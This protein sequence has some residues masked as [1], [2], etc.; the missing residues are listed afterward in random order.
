MGLPRELRKHLERL[1]ELG[2]PRVLAPAAP[3][4]AAE[5]FAPLVQD[6]ADR[7][8]GPGPRSFVV[9]GETAVGKTT[10]LQELVRELREGPEPMAVVQL[11]TGD[12][13]RGAKYIGE[14]EERLA[15]LIAAS[16]RPIPVVIW[17]TNV[18]DLIGAGM[19]E[20]SR[21]DMSKLLA[22]HLASGDVAVIGESSPSE[23]AAG[24]GQS[25]L[26]RLFPPIEL[27]PASDTE[28]LTIL[29]EVRRAFREH[30]PGLEI[31]VESVERVLELSRLL[32]AVGE[33]PGRGI[34]LFEMALMAAIEED[35]SRI[36]PAFV[37][38]VLAERTGLPKW[39]FDDD[40]AI[41]LEELEAF[42]TE[43]VLGQPEAVATMVDVIALV[44]AGLNDPGKPLAVLFFV[45]PTGVGKT[46]IAKALAERLFGS[47]ERMV[48]ID[49]SEFGDY[50]AAARLIGY[51]GSPGILTERVK[52]QP[53]SVIL[54]D[55]IEKAADIAFDLFLQVFDDGRLSDGS[56]VTV[57]F[58]QTIVVMT[59]NLGS[60]R[61]RR[62]TLG[63]KESEGPVEDPLLEAVQQFFRPEFVNRIDQ[64]VPFRPLD[65]SVLAKIAQREVGRILVRSGLTRRR[66]S[67]DIDPSVTSLLVRSGTSTRYGARPMKRAVERLVLLPLARRIATGQAPIGGVLRLRA[68]GS[69]VIADLVKDPRED[70]V[71]Q[72][73]QRLHIPSPLVERRGSLSV[74]DLEELVRGLEIRRDALRDQI[75]SSGL[76]EQKSGLVALTQRRDFWDD[77]SEARRVLSRIHGIEGLIDNVHRIGRRI[78]SL[79]GIV[80]GL[81]RRRE[82][83]PLEKAAQRY[84]DVARD[85]ELVEFDLSCRDAVDREDAFLRLTRVPARVPVERDFLALLGAMYQRWARS[86]A[87][88]VFVL[89][90]SL[91]DR[92]ADETITLVVEG[93]CAFGLLKGERGLHVL[94]EGGDRSREGRRQ[95]THVR[96][97]VWPCRDDEDAEPLLGAISAPE[98]ALNGPGRLLATRVTALR[99][100]HEASGHA[101]SARSDLPASRCEA[102]L[103]KLLG[104]I[105]AEGGDTEKRQAVAR[106]YAL[107]PEPKVR[108]ARSGLQTSDVQGVLAGDLDQFLL[109]PRSRRARRDTTTPE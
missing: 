51:P 108:D 49:M 5:R 76:A 22:P 16:S 27:Q 68:A 34:Q 87:F 33:Q 37:A 56:G 64:I 109:V 82:R 97:E 15:Q 21:Q 92:G 2:Y 106:R 89:D 30:A 53:F 13:L 86:K 35:C 39:I 73:K 11:T 69:R 65:A 32:K 41:D 91:G 38:R 25:S 48:R 3:V 72:L 18:N 7:L 62:E 52:Q 60:E 100:F 12:I 23:Y 26:E 42:F 103:R 17:L 54:L 99:L 45:G 77:P 46:E 84:R 67:V 95:R 19:T 28:T 61:M 50:E 88:D 1:G 14:W 10:L 20:G 90:D 107:A 40:E 79:T 96:V 36:S 75:E 102:L 43:R 31:P 78:D 81:G 105:I 66:L 24:L 29:G 85:L 70:E 57:D 63:F 80:Q 58:R 98:V 93:A 101:I 8:R 83:H 104:E 59:S 6:L 47:R 4:P 55:E 71:E 94:D 9:V 44:K 74:A